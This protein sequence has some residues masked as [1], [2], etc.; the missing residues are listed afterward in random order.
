MIRTVNG[1]NFGKVIPR[2]ISGVAE[3]VY[4]NVQ[5]VRNLTSDEEHWSKGHQTAG[6]EKHRD[7]DFRERWL[8]SYT[9]AEFVER[10]RGF[11]PLYFVDLP[12]DYVVW[13]YR[14][15]IIAY[16]LGLA[17]M[18]I[19]LAFISFCLWKMGVFMPLIFHSLII[20]H[21]GPVL[22][23]VFCVFTWCLSLIRKI[24]Y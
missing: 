19:S 6:N 11:V 2:I 8:R 9:R 21:Q 12:F 4:E 18:M 15:S 14:E 13:P 23:S 3:E 5:V 17:V 10:I 24:F 16:D 7:E 1:T 20:Y 22:F